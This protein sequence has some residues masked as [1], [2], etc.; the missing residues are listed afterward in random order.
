MDKD[1]DSLLTDPL[2][3][4][5]PLK[6]YRT[7]FQQIESIPG[8]IQ[9]IVDTETSQLKRQ[10]QDDLRHLDEDHMAEVAHLKRQY[11][12]KLQSESATTQLYR[13]DGNERQAAGLES[14]REQLGHPSSAMAN[15]D[16]E[17]PN[18]DE[19]DI[20]AVSEQQ[21]PTFVW[22][23][24]EDIEPRLYDTGQ[25]MT[26]ATTTGYPPLYANRLRGKDDDHDV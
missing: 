15:R 21:E 19:G 5:P 22:D 25:S 11:E 12:A 8:F 13:E 9:G 20:I 26:L 3:S 1:L 16:G 7:L 24:I 18:S 17:V 10:F 14:P 6:L 2:A 23:E 4:K